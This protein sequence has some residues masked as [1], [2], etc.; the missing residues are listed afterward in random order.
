M[1]SRARGCLGRVSGK[2]RSS[3]HDGPAKDTPRAA[4]AP[5][6]G[7][8]ATIP[9]PSTGSKGGRARLRAASG[10]APPCALA[11]APDMAVT[12]Q[13]IALEA[14]G[15]VEEAGEAARLC[16]A[17]LSPGLLTVRRAVAY[18]TADGEI[19]AAPGL[20][21]HA[22]RA[23]ASPQP[24]DR[25]VLAHRG[26]GWVRGGLHHALSRI[27]AVG[28]AIAVDGDMLTLVEM[29]AD[30]RRS[31]AAAK[32]APVAVEGAVDLTRL[33]LDGTDAAEGEVR[34]WLEFEKTRCCILAQQMPPRL[35]QERMAAGEGAQALMPTNRL[36]A[37]GPISG[38][39]PPAADGLACGGGAA[40]PWRIAAA[41]ARGCAAR[42]AW[43]P[44]PRPKR[45]PGR[46]RG[47]GGRCRARHPRPAQGRHPP[48][49]AGRSEPPPVARLSLFLSP[50]CRS[51]GGGEDRAF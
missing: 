51:R 25:A 27:G 13:D 17:P 8:T 23:D 4:K 30:V 42:W 49:G 47:R 37:P 16:A 20:S 11:N 39:E 45:W 50:R 48:G 5:G 21:R 10:G 7:A 41:A 15:G 14:A 44:P 36:L 29:E 32:G 31:D 1:R 40:G 3:S 35:A 2:A 6:R 43:R 18:S 12:V 34:D 46:S 24:A 33:V 19:G 9:R 26:A 38:T 22:A 28:G